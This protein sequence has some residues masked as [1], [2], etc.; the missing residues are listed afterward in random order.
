M[1]LSYEIYGVCV[2]FYI[3]AGFSY[4]GWCH[5]LTMARTRQRNL[6]IMRTQRICLLEILLECTCRKLL[7][8]LSLSRIYFIPLRSIFI[9][10]EPA[11][12]KDEWKTEHTAQSRQPQTTAR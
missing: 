12:A 6:F 9:C 5:V 10:R 8:N 4:E 2:C 7:T 11:R 3:S 1:I